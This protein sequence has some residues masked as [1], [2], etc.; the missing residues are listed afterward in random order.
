MYSKIKLFKYKK[1]LK[2][3]TLFNIYIQYFIFVNKNRKT[4]KN[5]RK[6]LI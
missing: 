3:K 6:L 2:V 5:Y 4:P 1:Y